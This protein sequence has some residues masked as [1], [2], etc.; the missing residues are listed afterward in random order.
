M[1]I[2]TKS[3]LNDSVANAY[4]KIFAPLRFFAGSICAY[5]QT[6]RKITEVSLF[7]AGRREEAKKSESTKSPATD[8]NKTAAGEEINLRASSLPIENA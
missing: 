3:C 1:E 4:D 7:S 5:P 8:L 2:Y 6:S